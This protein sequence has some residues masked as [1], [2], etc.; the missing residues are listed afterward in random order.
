MEM[1]SGKTWGWPRAAQC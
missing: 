1:I